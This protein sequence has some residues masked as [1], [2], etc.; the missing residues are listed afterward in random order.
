VEGITRFLERVWR[1]IVDEDVRVSGAVVS[2]APSLDH[3]RFAA[4]DDQEGDG[5]H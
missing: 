4:S 2:S 5:R 3:Q 1:L